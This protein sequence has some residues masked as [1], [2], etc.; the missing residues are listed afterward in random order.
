MQIT[1]EGVRAGRGG[2]PARG[3]DSSGAAVLGG[4]SFAGCVRGE[5]SRAQCPAEGCETFPGPPAHGFPWCCL[6]ADSFPRN[7]IYWALFLDT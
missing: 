1:L 7:A 5:G 4:N 6:R 2:A 3:R